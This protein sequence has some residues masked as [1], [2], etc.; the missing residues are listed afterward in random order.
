MYIAIAALIAVTC[1]LYPDSTVR[2]A[3][4]GPAHTLVGI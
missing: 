2:W 4:I 3:R 1:H